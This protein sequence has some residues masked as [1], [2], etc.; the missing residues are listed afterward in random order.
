MSKTTVASTG[1]DLSDTFAFTGTVTGATDLVKISTTTVSSS[2][3]TVEFTGIDNT[4]QTYMVSMNNV[5]FSSDNAEFRCQVGTDSAYI[6][7][8]YSLTGTAG[9]AGSTTVDGVNMTSEASWGIYG[10]FHVGA[11]TNETY[12]GNV[13]FYN[14]RLTVG[15]KHM[16][17][18]SS[19]DQDGGNV[20]NTCLSG[21]QSDNSAMTKIK[22]GDLSG[23]RTIETG[24]FT[25]Y[26]V[27][28]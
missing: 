21:A 27:K 14:L 28:Q 20:V 16:I 9:R 7:A 2:A 6:T 10:G 23:S 13:F 17:S 8:N 5:H 3:A 4:F 22:F 15:K 24:V 25:L 26:G 12:N 19:H 11:D 1:I 18:V